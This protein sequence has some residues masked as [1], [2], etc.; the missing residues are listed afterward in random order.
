MKECDVAVQSFN[1]PES[2]I[3]TLLS[4]KKY[5]GKHIDK[6]YINDDCSKCDMS[7]YYLN[8]KFIN[9]MKPIKIVYRRNTKP[10][11]YSYTL[12]TRE[13]W[14]KKSIIKKLQLIGFF[15][16]K[17]AKIYKT[18][19]DVRYQWAINNTDKKY[20]MLIHDD[21]KFYDDILNIYLEGINDS[22]SIVGDLGGSKLCE[23]GPCG[24]KNCCPEKIVNGIYPCKNWPITG[25]RKNILL[26][27]LGRKNYNCR[28]NEWCCLL[29]VNVTKK[30]FE[31]K[32]IYFGNYEDGGDVGTYWLSEAIKMGYKFTDPIP[33]F[34]E[35]KRYYLHWWQGYEGHSVWIKK[36]KYERKLII[37]SLLR[38]FSFDFNEIFDGDKKNDYGEKKG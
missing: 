8:P 11:G 12:V 16:I 1:K 6:I 20:L 5:C 17:R 34:E 32:G 3:Y 9:L 19:N 33:R 7:K 37:D 23:F 21:I 28:I 18:S 13:M 25:K 2:L 30:I 29:N 38:D 14:K 15:I 31:R 26:R 4:L 27:I 35:R 24:T 10:S 36:Q 22:Y